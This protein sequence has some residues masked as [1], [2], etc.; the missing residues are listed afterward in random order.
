M[1][2]L[3]GIGRFILELD[4][5]AAATNA[6]R[7]LLGHANHF[8]GNAMQQ[9]RRQQNFRARKMTAFGRS[10]FTLQSLGERLQSTIIVRGR[11]DCRHWILMAIAMCM[12]VCMMV[13]SVMVGRGRR[14]WGRPVCKK[15]K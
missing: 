1:R 11:Y 9:I 15:H 10:Q 8:A 12:M 2:F 3:P 14:Q 13:L 5:H 7:F 4:E 6:A